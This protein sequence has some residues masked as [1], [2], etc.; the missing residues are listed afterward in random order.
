[1]SGLGF[2]VLLDEF[3]RPQIADFKSSL[4]EA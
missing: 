4:V 2:A 1:M 3:G